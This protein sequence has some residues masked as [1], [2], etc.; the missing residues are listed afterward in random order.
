MRS[1]IALVFMI[2]AGSVAHAQSPPMITDDPGT[3]GDRRWEINVGWGFERAG[4]SHA[5]HEAPLLDINYGI[6]ERLQVKYEVPWIVVEGEG[7]G[8]GN[9]MLGVKWRFLDQGEAGWQMSTYPQVVLRNPGSRSVERG[10]AED[11]TTVLLPFQFERGFE[12]HAVGFELG[13]V[14]H[15]RQDDEWY[16]GVVLSR[17]FNERMEGF[18]ELHGE[19]LVGF[20]RSAVTAN[21]GTRWE[22]MEHGAL[23][24]SLGHELHDGLDESEGT[25]GYAGW[26][27]SF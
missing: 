17:S 26:Q 18:A 14:F 7:S 12:S 9:S 11:G 15:S 16:G 24:L 10:F 5:E 19:S 25:I 23:L 3:P 6:G 8:L 20:E 21:V 4:S 22:L 1:T 2:A 27:V 13:R